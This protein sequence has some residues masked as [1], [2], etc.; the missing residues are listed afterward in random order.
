MGHKPLDRITLPPNVKVLIMLL[1]LHLR[2]LSSSHERILLI[3]S[4]PP[5]G[6]RL[7]TL[8]LVAEVTAFN[9]FAT[10]SKVPLLHQGP[11]FP[12]R[13]PTS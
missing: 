4:K 2:T 5:Q 7:G 10:N 6:L 3:R 1:Q 12:P 9:I 8:R 13:K 11:P